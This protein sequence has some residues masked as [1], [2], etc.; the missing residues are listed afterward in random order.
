MQPPRRPPPRPALKKAL[1][2]E[3][4][5]RGKQAVVSCSGPHA[6]CAAEWF[7]HLS[8]TGAPPEPDDF[9]TC[10]TEVSR[11]DIWCGHYA[12]YR[13]HPYCDAMPLTQDLGEGL[14][15]SPAG[16]RLTVDMEESCVP[17]DL[18]YQFRLALYTERQL[19]VL[20][21]IRGRV[22]KKSSRGRHGGCRPPCP[23]QCCTCRTINWA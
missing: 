4:M 3:R 20:D 17:S 12:L 1:T 22:I 19:E 8:N 7:A 18:L 14:A 21:P 6:S 9:T 5:Q 13:K 15:V 10:D 16:M 23:Q 2:A 11:F